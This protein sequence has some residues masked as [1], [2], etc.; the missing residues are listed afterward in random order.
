MVSR[1]FFVRVLEAIILD[2]RHCLFQLPE[3]LSRLPE[4]QAKAFLPVAQ[5]DVNK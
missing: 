3:L 5:N 1:H 4:N 2:T